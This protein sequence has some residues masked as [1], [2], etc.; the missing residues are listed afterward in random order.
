VH[1]APAF[2]PFDQTFPQMSLVADKI[3]YTGYVVPE[4]PDPR[5]D[6]LGA[7]EVIV[8]TGGGAVSEPLLV[9]ALAAR[10]LTRLK[11][12]TWR[13]RVGHNLPEDQFA[14]VRD[15]AA[16]VGSVPHPALAPGL[17]VGDTWL[18]RTERR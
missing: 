6:S 15:G 10:P 5:S 12:A 3:R 13:V 17:R 1:G 16:P 14:R 9:A 2:V 11:D 18:Q 4:A 8:S 7:G